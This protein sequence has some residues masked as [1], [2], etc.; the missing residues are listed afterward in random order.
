MN[1]LWGILVIMFLYG[2]GHVSPHIV[3]N[4]NN[5]SLP[6]AEQTPA[7]QTPAGKAITQTL[8]N[9]GRLPPDECD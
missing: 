3:P 9:A 6:L 5:Y 1:K 4:C 7:E 2:C 8:C